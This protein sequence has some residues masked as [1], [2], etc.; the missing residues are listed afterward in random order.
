[1]GRFKKKPNLSLLPLSFFPAQRNTPKSLFRG[2]DTVPES[3]NVKNMHK[4]QPKAMRLGETVLLSRVHYSKAGAGF[5]NFLVT[6]AC[7]L[8][9]LTFSCVITPKHLSASP[10]GSDSQLQL[11][12]ASLT[13]DS[14]KQTQTKPAIPRQL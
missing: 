3:M 7:T 5:A 14:R 10:R 1:M 4:N 9:D 6:I 11:P 8:R 13:F 2:E 12:Q